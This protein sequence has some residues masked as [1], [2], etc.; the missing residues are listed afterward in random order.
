MTTDTAGG[1]VVDRG[2]AVSGGIGGYYRPSRMDS[3]RTA[4]TGSRPDL[5]EID[6]WIR[7][8]LPGATSFKGIGYL[9]EYVRVLGPQLARMSLVVELGVA[10]GAS[11]LAWSRLCPQANC[12]GV[13][14]KFSPTLPATLDRLKLT[15]R[16]SLLEC[17]HTDVRRIDAAIEGS[18]DLIVDD[19]SHLLEPARRCFFGLF[20]RLAPEGWYCL[21]DWGAGY[22]ESYG[23][24]HAG[25]HRLLYEVL[26]EIAMPDRVK[27]EAGRYRQ[28]GSGMPISDFRVSTVEPI[29]FVQRSRA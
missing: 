22:W 17:D 20:E 28:V 25:V 5:E 26:D 9:A 14:R 4:S 12:L 29:A 3:Q 7:R 24:P 15:D 16:V 27:P 6:R 18:P 2:E 13:D 1:A 8:E 21:E 19:G 10:E 11:L 23:G